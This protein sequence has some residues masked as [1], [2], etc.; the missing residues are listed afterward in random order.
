MSSDDPYILHPKNVKKTKVIN[1]Q[2]MMA[3]AMMK[4][5]MKRL[6]IIEASGIS[7]DF[8]SKIFN[9]F[10]DK[11]LDALTE[12]IVDSWEM[13]IKAKLMNVTEKAIDGI[14][15][16]LDEGNMKSAKLA[17]EIFEKT[18]NSFRLA[19]GKTTGNTEATVNLFNS[20]IQSR[21]QLVPPN[22]SQI[23]EIVS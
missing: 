18:F 16:F 8:Y 1:A 11:N 14:E 5:G 20:V 22:Q 6:D 17:S 9:E 15:E 7:N 19:T 23:K 12:K 21:R 2:R 13:L 3:L 10:K 4:A